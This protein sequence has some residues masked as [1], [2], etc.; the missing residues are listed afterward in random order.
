MEFQ[1]CSG[2]DIEQE[3]RK[4]KRSQDIRVGDLRLPNFKN[5]LKSY[6]GFCSAVRVIGQ[7][8]KHFKSPGNPKSIV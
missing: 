3:V 8:S 2:A 7:K 1:G 4:G 6:W 5:V